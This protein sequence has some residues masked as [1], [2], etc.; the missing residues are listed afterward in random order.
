LNLVKIDNQ[1]A[2][3]VFSALRSGHPESASRFAPA[4]SGQLPQHVLC[5]NVSAGE[6]RAISHQPEESVLSVRTNEDHVGEI[7]DQLSTLKLLSG[8]PP[9]ALHFGSPGRN[10]FAFYNQLALTVRFNDG[11]LE[12][13]V[14]A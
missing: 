5:E 13:S 3:L 14:S 4:Y 1:N 2:S 12:H 8:T 11:D 6:F 7:D 9:S 10:E